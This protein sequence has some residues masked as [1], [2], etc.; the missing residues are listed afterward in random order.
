MT[1]PDPVVQAYKR[2]LDRALIRENLKRT[3]TERFENSMA[4]QRFAAE[5]ESRRASVA[6]NVRVRK[7]VY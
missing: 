3:V 1:D 5:R 6:A 4:L 7:I 2:N